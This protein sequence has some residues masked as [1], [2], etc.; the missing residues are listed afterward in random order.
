M[1]LVMRVEAFSSDFIEFGDCGIFSL[2]RE[3]ES[4]GMPELNRSSFISKQ[5]G[6][7]FLG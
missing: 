4:G 6:N 5:G 7:W 1:M 2:S 3:R